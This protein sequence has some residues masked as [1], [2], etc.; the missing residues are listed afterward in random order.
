[1]SDP[2]VGYSGTL[3]FDSTYLTTKDRLFV[4]FQFGNGGAAAFRARC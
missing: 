4:G 1:V 3:S 2:D